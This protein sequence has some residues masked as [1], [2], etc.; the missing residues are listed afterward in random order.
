MCIRATDYLPPVDPTFSDF[1]R[2]MVTADFEINQAD[3]L[4]LRGSMI[5]AFRL[6]GIRP[7]AVGSLAVESLLLTPEDTRPAGDPTLAD[8]VRRVL[9]VGARDM[10][11][12]TVKKPPSTPAGG[13]KTKAVPRVRSLSEWV[14]Q[15]QVLPADAD[16]EAEAAITEADEPDEEFRNIAQALTAWAMGKRAEL[17]LDPGRRV[18]VQGFHPVHR[19]APSGEL[20][21]EMV[22]QLVQ[23]VKSDEDLGGLVFRAGVTIVAMIDGHVRYVIRKPLDTTREKALREWVAA[24]DEERGPAWPTGPAARNRITEAFSLRAIDARRWD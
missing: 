23:S 6:R 18:Q 12:R 5:E 8:I 15:Q 3:E 2:A 10:N 22:A 20:L 1:L 24:F 17:G 14:V 19:I 7:E 9:N 13:R 21:V 4:G 16:P 11:E